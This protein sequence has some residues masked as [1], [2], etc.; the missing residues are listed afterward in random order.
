[1]KSKEHSGEELCEWSQTEGG[2]VFTSYEGHKCIH[3][4]KVR[5]CWSVASHPEEWK[6]PLSLALRHNKISSMSG[7]DADITQKRMLTSDVSEE[8]GKEVSAFL[9]PRY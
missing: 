8:R 3:V 7:I 6:Y 9:G 5:K 1:M 2:A 4:G